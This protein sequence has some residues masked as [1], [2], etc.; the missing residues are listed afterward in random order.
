MDSKVSLGAWSWDVTTG[1]EF[2]VGAGL[3]DPYSLIWCAV[4][5]FESSATILRLLLQHHLHVNVTHNGRTLLHHAILCNNPTAVSVLLDSGADVEFP[6]KTNGKVEFRS[7]HMAARFGSSEILN[8]LIDFGCEID[9]RTDSGET[10]VMLCAKYQ[11]ENCL[12]PLVMAGADLLLVNFSGDSAVSIAASEQW[13]AEFQRIVMEVISASKTP[14]FSPLMFA[15]LCGDVPSLQV[16]LA[17][18]PSTR[19][20]EQDENGYSAVMIA[21]KEGHVDAFRFLVFAGANM[22]LR[23]KFGET[24]MTISLSNTKKDLFENVILKYASE[25]GMESSPSF[26]ALHCA[27][28][29]GDIE[30][31][32]LLTAKGYDVNILDEND[33][34]PLMLAAREGH[35]EMCSLLISRGARCDIKTSRGE[36]ALSLARTNKNKSSSSSEV[37]LDE[38]SRVL[39]LRGCNLRKHTKGGRGSPHGKMLRMVDGKLRWGSSSKR[40]VVCK[41]VEVGASLPFRRCRRRKGDDYDPGTFRVV[42]TKN[43]EVHFVCEGGIENAELWVRGIRL[44]TRI[45]GK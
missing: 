39:V 4:E 8:I 28:R 1:E 44:L 35:D 40:N 32:R 9:S 45:V 37:V 12:R 23:N 25:K 6:V 33:Y 31:V 21:A 38:L 30:V 17:S 22:K 15:S 34:T 24:A 41:E 11:K 29:R 10:A 20:D 3:S 43:K 42:T 13:S 5:Y 18:L 27:S 2:R 14:I 36:T 26:N 16:L 7:I 19:V